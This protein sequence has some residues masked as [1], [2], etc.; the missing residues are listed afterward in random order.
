MVTVIDVDATW[1]NP[2]GTQYDAGELRR[3]DAAMFVTPGVTRVRNGGDLWVTVDGSD[4]V[5]V[6]RGQCVI[7]GDKAVAGAGAYRAGL[8]DSV[9]KALD[10]RHGTYGRIDLVVFRVLDKD[11]VSSHGIYTGRVEVIAGTPSAAPVVPVKPS[12]SIE[13]GRITVPVL[14]GA[15][16]TVDSSY[17]EYATAAGGSVLV[18][19]AAR[20][21]DLQV[22][23]RQRGM[24]LDE[25]VG[26]VLQ[27]GIW[28][29]DFEAARITAAAPQ[30]IGNAGVDKELTNLT[31]RVRSDGDLHTA[32]TSSLRATVAGWYKVGAQVTWDSGGGAAGDI[33]YLRIMK[34]QTSAIIEDRG[35]GLSGTNTINA[36]ATEVYLDAGDLITVNV[37]QSSGAAKNVV[38]GSAGAPTHL[39]ASRRSA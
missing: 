6:S 31:T 9:S 27:N 15:A 3:A 29:R 13:L 23:D 2:G 35:P 12:M 11:V 7:F 24:T 20:F 38:V 21:A 5:S 22:Q 14:G 26:Y 16:A 30:L 18:P 4:N 34:N 8:A 39:W 28:V 33:R 17:R 10:G 25:G 19:T 37:Y 36:A 32:G 1:M